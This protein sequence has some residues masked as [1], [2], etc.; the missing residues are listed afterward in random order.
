MIKVSSMIHGRSHPSCILLPDGNVA[1]VNGID[2]HGNPNRL[3]EVYDYN[4][5]KWKIK[6][7]PTTSFTYCVSN[8]S[9]NHNE[10]KCAQ[11]YG[12]SNKGV[13]SD[14]GITPRMHVMPDGKVIVCGMGTNIRLWD[15]KTGTWRLLTNTSIPRYYGTSFLLPLMNSISERGKILLVGGS[16]L[17]DENGTSKVEILD[18]NIGGSI[19]PTIREVQ[20]LKYK[21]KM[22][23]PIILPNGKLVIFGG[24]KEDNDIPVY[25]PEMFDPTTETWS[26]LDPASIPRLKN[27]VSILL[28]DG[29]VWTAGGVNKNEE[30]ERRTEIFSPDYIFKERPIISGELVVKSYGGNILIP[31]PNPN[32]ISKVSLVKLMST[33]Q[34]HESNQRL[35]WLDIHDKSSNV[36]IVSAPLN[37]N[38]APPGMYMVHILNEANVPSY[39]HIIKIHP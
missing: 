17:Q 3:L 29:R 5:D 11:C 15:P 27:H 33:T 18:F 14:T 39:A 9:D 31:T 20:S 4:L 38:L 16:H 22:Q 6:F 8:I 36:I 19:S 10:V 2:E 1:A 26:I 28:P 30:W 25:T 37:P 7:D 32:S 13:C 24:S 21:R 35:L 12:S 34:Y 23:S